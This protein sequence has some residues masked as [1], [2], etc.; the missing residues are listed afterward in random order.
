MTFNFWFL[1]GGKNAASTI[2]A[3]QRATGPPDARPRPPL[4]IT[5]RVEAFMDDSQQPVIVAPTIQNLAPRRAP[6]PRPQNLQFLH[7]VLDLPKVARKK[8]VGLLNLLVVELLEFKI[9][10]ILLKIYLQG[11]GFHLRRRFHKECG[12]HPFKRKCSPYLQN[13]PFQ[14]HQ[15]Q[16][17]VD[18]NDR[19]Q[20]FHLILYQGR[21]P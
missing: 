14:G 6:A 12:T 20:H 17:P 19:F 2:Q 1:T 15:D 16:V 10:H 21:A 7:N 5:D 4:P 9:Y 3:I 13:F 18:H 11:N 8:E